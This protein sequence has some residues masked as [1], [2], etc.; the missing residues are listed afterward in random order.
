MANWYIFYNGQQIGP[1]PEKDLLAYNPSS[2]TMVWKEGMAQWQP[3]YTIPELMY[4]INGG[5][6]QFNQFNPQSSQPQPPQYGA[7]SYPPPA[8]P[9][10]SG[11][12]KTVAG[13]LAIILGGLGV[14]YFYIGKIGAGF[15][16]IL[17]T[18]VTCGIWEILTFIQGIMMLTM[19]QQE[20]DQKYV[21][22]DKT[23]PLF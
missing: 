10:S 11:K 17:L 8:G 2:D 22:N 16:T 3:I 15:L 5:G 20:F 7:G 9:R 14:Q 13:V 19:S 6:Q 18:I 21:F 4:L 1:M 12:D 23:L